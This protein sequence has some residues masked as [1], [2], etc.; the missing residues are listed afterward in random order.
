MPLSNGVVLNDIDHS[1]LI[2]TRPDIDNL[3]LP[4]SLT[5]IYIYY[6][7]HAPTGFLWCEAVMANAMTG[8]LD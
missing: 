8:S 5:V 4:G 7:Q 2:A 6:K 1:S 3:Q